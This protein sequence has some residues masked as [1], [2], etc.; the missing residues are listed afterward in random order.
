M[1]FKKKMKK[2][3]I[4]GAG[5]LGQQIAYH[6]ITD[7]HFQPVGFFDDIIK[8]GE[9]MCGLPVLGAV[10]DVEAFFQKKA[11]DV[12]LIGIGYKHFAE[13]A[14]FYDQF[15]NGI[16]IEF[17]H[18]FKHLRHTISSTLADN[19]DIA[20]RQSD[21]VAQANNM[22]CFFKSLDHFVRCKLFHA[23]CTSFYGCELWLI[24]NGAIE[25]LCAAW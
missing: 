7:Q 18:S 10:K 22:L 21:F 9:Q 20:L 2:M 4:I 16:P 12:L 23:F 24:T 15:I 3:A 17:V 19:E 6:A 13:R 1:L 8:T 5:D 25:G 14:R 11:F